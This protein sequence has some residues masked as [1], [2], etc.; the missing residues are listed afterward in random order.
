MKSL[1]RIVIA[2][3]FSQ[4][5]EDAKEMALRLARTFNSEILLIHVI[6]E[7]KDYPVAKSKIRK[8]VTEKLRQMKADLNR[9]G[10]SSVETVVKFGIP[11]EWII[12]HSDEMD[13]NVIVLGSGEKVKG[14]RFHL[15][16]TA[17][18]VVRHANKPVWVVKSGSPPHIR[19]IV[20]PVASSETSRRALT[21]AVHLARTFEAHLTVLTVF[22]PLL[23]D[24]FGVGRTPGETKEKI[25]KRRQQDQFDRFLRAFNFESLGWTKMLRRG[26]AHEEILAVVH[27]TKSNLLVMG[28]EGRTGLSRMLVGSTTERVVRE[29]PCSMITLK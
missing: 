15:G 12:E 11:F 16:T 13:A 27:E 18:R 21:N 1:E 28:S 14:E 24:Y 2:T 20:Y 7:F 17:E 5:S 10:I 4:A 19:K 22:E 6:P 9:Q 25:W 29:M 8:A 23:S 26:K 3:D